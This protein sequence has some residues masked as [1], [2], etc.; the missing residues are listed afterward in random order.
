MT[1]LDHFKCS[2]CP[3]GIVSVLIMEEPIYF[4]ITVMDCN[5]CMHQFG[6]KEL[7]NLKKIGVYNKQLELFNNTFNPAP[8]GQK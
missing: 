5:I 6:L 4:K 7:H 1:S 2:K 3:N 8:E